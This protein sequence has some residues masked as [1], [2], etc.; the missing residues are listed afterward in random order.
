[1]KPRVGE[2]A[3]DFTA[4]AVDAEGESSVSLESL[5]GQRFILYFYPKDHT[6]GCTIQACSLR[7]RWAE[8][9]G[10]VKVFGVSGDDV[11]SHSRFI[12]G[13]RLPFSLIADTDQCLAIAF[14]V[15]IEKS[16]LGRKFMRTERSSF[17][18]GENG[19][20]E[21]VLERVSPLNHTARL[22]A[23]LG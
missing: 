3:P 23:A 9:G 18:V 17:V 1:M 12:K 11:E 13:R 4:L 5:S 15:W 14:G 20:V 2:K 10:R 22:L 8:F 16:M 19:F 7:E 21:T 6:P